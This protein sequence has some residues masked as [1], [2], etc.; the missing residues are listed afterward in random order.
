MSFKGYRLEAHGLPNGE[1]CDTTAAGFAKFVTWNQKHSWC[2]PYL[3]I[4]IAGFPEPFLKSDPVKDSIYVDVFKH[5]V[6]PRITKDTKI[7]FSMWD[8]D[9]LK[10]DLIITQT[11]T[12]GECLAET[13][14]NVSFVRMIASLF[15][16]YSICFFLDRAHLRFAINRAERVS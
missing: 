3:E 8:K 4:Y 10:G 15:I 14:Q 1:N 9:V 5:F 6:T 7:A 11:L 12:A 16:F 2:D 13:I